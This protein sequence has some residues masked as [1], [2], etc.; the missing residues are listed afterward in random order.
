[1]GEHDVHLNR[2]DLSRSLRCAKEGKLEQ[3]HRL[4]KTGENTAANSPAPWRFQQLLVMRIE[5]YSLAHVIA[6]AYAERIGLDPALFASH[7]M[8][9]GFLTSAAK[10]S[11]STF[12]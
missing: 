7:S 6:K 8:R 1:M 11:A 3:Q 9:S 4:C 10:R 12:K 2:T 5:Y